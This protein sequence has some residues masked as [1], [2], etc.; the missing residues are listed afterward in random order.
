MINQKKKTADIKTI[1]QLD[2]KVIRLQ[3]GIGFENNDQISKYL[4]E[5]TTNYICINKSIEKTALAYPLT[6][7]R[8]YEQ[9]N[10]KDKFYENDKQYI[11]SKPKKEKTS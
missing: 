4:K 7:A 10:K 1:E 5:N 11:E 3:G 9:E 6:Y 2:K 8:L